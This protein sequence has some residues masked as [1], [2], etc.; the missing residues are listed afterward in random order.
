[1]LKTKFRMEFKVKRGFFD[2]CQYYFSSYLKETTNTESDDDT[3]SSSSSDDDDENDVGGGN[4]VRPSFRMAGP[5]KKVSTK[6][7]RLLL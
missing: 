6:D 1:M 5:Y 4:I 2:K 7:R 3:S